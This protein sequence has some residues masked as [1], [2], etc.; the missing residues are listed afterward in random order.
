MTDAIQKSYDEMM[1]KLAK[2]YP[3][4][5]RQFWR[6]DD[7]EDLRDHLK[8][9]AAAVDEHILD[10]GREA[11][12]QA[13]GIHVS[14]FTGLLTDAM[15]DHAVFVLDQAAEELREEISTRSDYAE[16]NTLNRAMQGV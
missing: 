4:A 8:S 16:H 7:F 9:I 12:S 2:L 3:V 1:A 5:S 15:G 14:D 13:Y 10:C 6:A 11:A